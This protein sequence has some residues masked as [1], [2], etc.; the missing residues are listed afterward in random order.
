[1]SLAYKTGAG[2]NGLDQLRA[3]MSSGRKPGILASLDFELVEIDLGKAVFAGKPGEHAYNPLGTVH[4]GY[5]ATLLDSA[6][7][8]AVHSSLTEKQAYTTLELKIS[9]HKA[10]IKNTGLVRAEGSVLSLGR[11]AAFADARLIDSAGRLYASATST[12]LIFG[13]DSK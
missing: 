11:R 1:M 13:R 9:Y 5:A 6:C 2:L 7:G 4:G 10:M 12:L 3:L 8:C